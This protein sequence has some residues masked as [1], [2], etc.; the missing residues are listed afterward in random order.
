MGNCASSQITNSSGGGG[1]AMNWPPTATAIVID[2]DGKLRQFGQPIR[3]CHVLSVN[4]NCFL[5]NSDAM[6]VGSPP[7]QIPADE[8]L[9]TGQ[10]YFLVPISKSHTPLSLQDLCELASKASTG[11]G[12]NVMYPE[13]RQ[14]QKI[15]N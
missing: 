1:G 12:T 14:T 10:I 13:E 6:F 15:R 7:P 11:L 5:C 3:A 4:P 8:E 9:Q 2:L